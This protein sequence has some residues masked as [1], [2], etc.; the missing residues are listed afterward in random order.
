MLSARTRKKYRLPTKQNGNMPHAQRRKKISVG[1]LRGRGDLATRGSQYHFAWSDRDIDDG[2][3]ETS[4][5]GRISLSGPAPSA[6][7]TWLGTSGNGFDYY[8]PYRPAP[9]WNP[10]GPTICNRRV[11]VAASW[12]SRFN[13]LRTTVRG[14]N[15]RLFSATTSASGS[16]ANASDLTRET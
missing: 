13:S 6:W 7:K 2:Y 15:V 11:I 3:P 10:R 12:K 14:S 16:C 1:N 8:E 5:G 9:K 4:A